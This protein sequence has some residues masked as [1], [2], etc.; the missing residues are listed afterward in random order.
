VSIEEMDR[1]RIGYDLFW[2]T[3]AHTCVRDYR[4]F[5]LA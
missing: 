3:H 4:T 5:D 2:D 1:M